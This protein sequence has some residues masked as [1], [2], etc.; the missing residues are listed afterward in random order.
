MEN[1]NTNNDQQQPQQMTPQGQMAP[2]MGAYGGY[3]GAPNQEALMQMLRTQQQQQQGGGGGQFD[4]NGQ[5]GA[6]GSAQMMPQ[7]GGMMMAGGPGM[8]P[9]GMAGYGMFDPS[10]MQQQMQMAGFGGFPGMQG[11]YG[12]GGM[13]PS[14]GGG[15]PGMY[16][17]GMQQPTAPGADPMAQAQN[18]T[19]N[20]AAALA[21]ASGAMNP[22]QVA[23]MQ[24]GAMM[25]PAAGMMGDP[26][27]FL[28]QMMQQPGGFYGGQQPGQFG[29]GAG[30]AG[31]TANAYLNMA[32]QAG[33]PT[34]NVAAD[35]MMSA[36]GMAGAGGLNPFATAKKT[37]KVKDKKKPKRPLSGTYLFRCSPCDT[38]FDSQDDLCLTITV[39]R[40]CCFSTAIGPLV[41]ILH[42]LQYFFCKSTS[43][44][45][46]TRRS[47]RVRQLT[48][49]FCADHFSIHAERRERPYPEG[50]RG[51]EK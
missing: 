44:F 2:G 6:D 35:G 13:D 45:S 10:Q 12:M 4:A 5:P 16:F 1:N 51:R 26:S 28:R 31:F 36:G 8:A 30:A 32:Q 7:Q 33:F 9:G 27:M 50:D 23:A 3:P 19:M 39:L 14:G 42:S 46:L 43:S 24:Q 38:F 22:Q 37:K 29:M 20:S 48:H 21:Q 49:F 18:N 47:S 40:L 17:P 15:M 25:N 11:G 41:S 34:G